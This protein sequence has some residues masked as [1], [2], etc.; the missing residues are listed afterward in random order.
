MAIIFMDGFEDYGPAGTTG[1]TLQYRLS[2]HWGNIDSTSG[3]PDAQIV[4]GRG[5]GFALG[6]GYTS[7]EYSRSVDETGELIVGFA[8]KVSQWRKLC[9]FSYATF[10]TEQAYLQVSVSGNI[11]V[12]NNTN[13]V[14]GS[15][16]NAP[17]RFNVWNY[18][19][20]RVKIGISD[21]EVEVILNGE[22]V[23]NE[24]G[25]DTGGHESSIIN[26][27]FLVPGADTKYDDLYLVDPNQA[28][29]N[30]FLGAISIKALHPEADTADADFTPST[31]ID[32]Y[33]M[34]D[35]TLVD[36]SEYLSSSTVGDLDLWDYEDA[37]AG[38]TVKCVQ[39]RTAGWSTATFATYAAVCKSGVTEYEQQSR[40][41]AT[42]NSILDCKSEY[43][44]VDPDTSVAWALAGF[45]SAQFGV[46]RK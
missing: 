6:E 15:T 40:G 4:T 42:D 21:G 32:N 20:F 44:E 24:T 7:N 9:V 37:P 39:V 45:N 27:F 38:T 10:T 22:Q 18:I 1:T 25:L 43:L 26:N 28:G 31:G 33:A 8:F 11:Y 16:N 5:G 34:V 41:L 19:E 23:I 35:D 14:L 46:K 3:S 13:A 2:R 12:Y 36:G 29:V 30:T 17:V